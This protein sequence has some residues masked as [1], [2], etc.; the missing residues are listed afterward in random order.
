MK[1]GSEQVVE[2]VCRLDPHLMS[3][4]TDGITAFKAAR[5]YPAIPVN[6]GIELEFVLF[7]KLESRCCRE[8][9]SMVEVPGQKKPSLA[10]L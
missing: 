5:V 4:V 6:R 9:Q 1:D 8:S 7:G 3:R 10:S 2:G